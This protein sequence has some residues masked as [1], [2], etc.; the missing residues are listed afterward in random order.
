[1]RPLDYYEN[2]IVI[3]NVE[4]EDSDEAFTRHTDEDSDI[5]AN[6]TKT[7]DQTDS[8]VSENNN[9]SLRNKIDRF[10]S[11]LDT[12]KNNRT[13]VIEMSSPLLGHYTPNSRRSCLSLN[14]RK[15]TISEKNRPNIVQTFESS[16]AAI[17]S[18]APN[19]ARFASVELSVSSMLDLSGS[20][21]KLGKDKDTLEN[22]SL[23]NEA[24]EKVENNDT[25]YCCCSCDLGILKRLPFIFFIPCSCLIIAISSIQM[26]LPP[27][28]IDQGIS[29][30]DSDFLITIISITEIFGTIGWGYIA[31]KGIISRNKI[32]SL[33]VC[34]IALATFGMPFIQSYSGFIA[35]SVWYGLFGRVYFSLY[36]I[37]LVDFLGVE[38]LGPALGIVTVFQTG[39]IAILQP[40]I[41]EFVLEIIYSTLF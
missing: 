39:F 40:V 12:N 32:I 11:A 26:F 34:S 1:M 20:S 30:K 18:S 31:D 4:Q 10:Y 8:K 5:K 14:G 3:A 28:A 36:P 15:R 24:K 16:L 17:S 2:T 33:A 41:G 6:N 27:H 9:G 35:F 19:I 25:Q 13:I 21:S 38:N 23:N 37:V 7:N 22:F 29:A